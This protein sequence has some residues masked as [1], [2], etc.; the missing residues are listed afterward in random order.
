MEV[1]MEYIGY[2]VTQSSLNN[3]IFISKDGKMVSHINCSI[4]KSDDE[5]REIVDFVLEM[6]DMERTAYLKYSSDNAD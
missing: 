4:K 2:T 1:E 3:H 6:R 5:L